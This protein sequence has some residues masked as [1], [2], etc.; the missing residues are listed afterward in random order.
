MLATLAT[1]SPFHTMTARLGKNVFKW[2]KSMTRRHP[3][4]DLGTRKQREVHREEE[5]F[6]QWPSRTNRASSTSRKSSCAG[7]ASSRDTPWLKAGGSLPWRKGSLTP[8]RIQSKSRPLEPMSSQCLQF[9]RT[10]WRRQSETGVQESARRGTPSRVVV[11]LL[12]F[13]LI[14]LALSLGLVLALGLAALDC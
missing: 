12:R 6:S 1:V 9:L 4:P 13:F 7:V 8:L 3:P 11:G 5:V 10:R 2:R 14:K